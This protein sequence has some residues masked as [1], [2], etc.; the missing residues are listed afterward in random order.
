MTGSGDQEYEPNLQDLVRSL[1]SL[2]QL[3]QEPLLEVRRIQILK[4]QTNGRFSLLLDVGIVH[5]GDEFQIPWNLS[6]EDMK[7]LKDTLNSL[8][9]D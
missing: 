1:N 3:R 6:S 4:D 8:C 9:L 2:V 7:E 5:T